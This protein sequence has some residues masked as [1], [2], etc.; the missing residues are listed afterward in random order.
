MSVITTETNSYS[1]DI[2]IVNDTD[3][4]IMSREFFSLR[5]T[6]EIVS[7]ETGGKTQR[8]TLTIATWHWQPIT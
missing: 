7:I 4:D 8:S 2:D 3:E 5:H 1:I 6:T